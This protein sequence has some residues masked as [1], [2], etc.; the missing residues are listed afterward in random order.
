MSKRLLSSSSDTSS[1]STS[2][3]RKRHARFQLLHNLPAS[4]LSQVCSFLS[5]H[6]TVS[7]LRST[8][9]ALHGSV[10]PNCLLQSHLAIS[11]RSL[12]ALIAATPSTRALISRVPSLTIDQYEQSCHQSVAQ[13][14]AD[15]A[16]FFSSLRRLS[17]ED[18]CGVLHGEVIELPFSSLAR[19]RALTHCRI[20]LK[21]LTS[22]ASLVPALSQLQSL[23]DLDLRHSE[24]AM[25]ELLPLLCADGAI[26][27]LLRLQSL[28]LPSYC[29]PDQVSSDELHDAFLCRLS[30][31]PAP[32]A[33]QRFSGVNSRHRAAGL[34]SVF[35]LP[36]LTQLDLGGWVASGEFL[37][38]TSRFASSFSS[39]PAPLVSLVLPRLQSEPHDFG[40]A[41]ARKAA[42]AVCSAAR[43]LLAR[44]SALRQLSCD[45]ETASG[46]LPVPDSTA[47]DDRLS[48]CGDRLYRLDVWGHFQL[49]SRYRSPFSPFA[50]PLSFPV[51]TELTI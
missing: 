42:M 9:H 8:C 13:L 26:P 6:E 27:L 39:S 18:H 28:L 23:T 29:Y 44:F 48:G 21:S 35:S 2:R 16:A 37:A 43:L 10:T 17:I 50:A 14:L 22:C 30:S 51:L 24:N 31:L 41:A 40:N 46:A 38:F 7:I 15:D 32:P 3:S 4:L 19:L 5:V 34:Q 45:P 1:P 33:L 12:P 25:P 47:P 49:P 20:H 11:S 36:H